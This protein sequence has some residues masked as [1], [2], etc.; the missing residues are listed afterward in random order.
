MLYE[1]ITLLAEQGVGGDED[2]VEVHLGQ[3]VA[4]ERA[5]REA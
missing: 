4:L 1:V 2:V 3:V 5:H